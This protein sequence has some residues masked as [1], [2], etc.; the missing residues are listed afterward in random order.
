MDPNI[1]N[2]GYGVLNLNA[3]I[4]SPDGKY[5]FGVFARNAMDTFFVAGTQANA[6][7]WTN[8]LNPESVRTVG[9]SFDAHF[10]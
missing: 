5:R 6:G 1:V 2:P 3:G 10:D 9:V 7:G 8:V 4:T